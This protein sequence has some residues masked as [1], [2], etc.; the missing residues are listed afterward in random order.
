MRGHNTAKIQI[1]YSKDR[2]S[3]PIQPS[4]AT[5]GPRTGNFNPVL[6]SSR[7]RNW[8][9]FDDSGLGCSHS[10]RGTA[11]VDMSLYIRDDGCFGWESSH[12]RVTGISTVVVVARRFGDNKQEFR[13]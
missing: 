10:L 12:K 8:P 9:R 11:Y 3:K 6:R 1:E 5:W 7:R 13:L 2:N 4:Y